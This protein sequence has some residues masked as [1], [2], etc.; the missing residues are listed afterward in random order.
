MQLQGHFTDPNPN[1]FKSIDQSKY[2]INPWG[3]L[4]FVKV[5]FYWNKMHI[6]QAHGEALD[7]IFISPETMKGNV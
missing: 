6:Y 1:S 5:A 3:K 7:A 4:G 2:F